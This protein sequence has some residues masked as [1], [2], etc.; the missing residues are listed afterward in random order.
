MTWIILSILRIALRDSGTRRRHDRRP[1]ER[2]KTGNGWPIRLI[3]PL[4]FKRQRRDR[5]ATEGLVRWLFA[6]LDLRTFI[7]QL[8]KLLDPFRFAN[9]QLI[10]NE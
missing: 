5:T 1:V 7:F 6:T 8:G 3:E 4:N 2:G 9:Q 10:W